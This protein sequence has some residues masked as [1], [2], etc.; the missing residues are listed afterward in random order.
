M[1]YVQNPQHTQ[2]QLGENQGWKLD[3]RLHLAWLPQKEYKTRLHSIDKGQ[4]NANDSKRVES[5]LTPNKGVDSCPLKRKE[6]Q[7]RKTGKGMST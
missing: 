6:K 1:L 2:L 7:S 5:Q 4:R 3:G